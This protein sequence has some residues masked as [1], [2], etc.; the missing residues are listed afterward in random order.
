MRSEGFTLL[1]FVIVIIIVGILSIIAVPVYRNYIEKTKKAQ[2]IFDVKESAAE[3]IPLKKI[4][5]GV[6][7]GN[8]TAGKSGGKNVRVT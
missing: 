7:D 5:A 3:N 4:L 1:E 2:N 6:S 8:V